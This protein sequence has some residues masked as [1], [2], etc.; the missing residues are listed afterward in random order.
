MRLFA[1]LTPRPSQQYQSS[2]VKCNTHTQNGA[3]TQPLSRSRLPLVGMAG[4]G[5]GGGV[6]ACSAG[7]VVVVRPL[8][9][10]LLEVLVVGP[11]RLLAGG[12]ALELELSWPRFH[13][14]CL[15]GQGRRAER[16][17]SWRIVGKRGGKLV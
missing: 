7:V 15:A 13:A 12:R 9:W 5:G 11:L 6:L 17:L 8:Q 3:T 1:F 10:A 4:E 2:G 14:E 16:R